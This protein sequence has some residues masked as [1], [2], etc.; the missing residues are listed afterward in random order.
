LKINKSQVWLGQQLQAF[1]AVDFLWSF[2]VN[3]MVPSP[4][5]F[6]RESGMKILFESFCFIAFLAIS[7]N[8]DSTFVDCCA[9]ASKNGIL[10]FVE[11]H[12]SA[13]FFYTC[14]FCSKS[15]LFPIRK[16]GNDA[17]SAGAALSKKV[18]FHLAMLSKDFESVMS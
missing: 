13:W 10:L 1:F 3:R 2:A 16:N 4:P 7:K 15:T 5:A 8:A 6:E 14:L 18:C 17:G 9:D 11:A 12:S